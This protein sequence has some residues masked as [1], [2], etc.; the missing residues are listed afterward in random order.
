M[1]P[2]LL[3]F[4]HSLFKSL[5]LLAYRRIFDSPGSIP[6]FFQRHSRIHARKIKHRR[7]S[8]VTANN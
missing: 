1:L 4:I 8:P 2:E 7:F 3:V 6:N 5:H